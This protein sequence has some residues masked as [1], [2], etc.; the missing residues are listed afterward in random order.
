LLLF[1]FENFIA[2]PNPAKGAF[3]STIVPFYG[4]LVAGEAIFVPSGPVF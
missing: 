4:D 1:R 3:A 2:R